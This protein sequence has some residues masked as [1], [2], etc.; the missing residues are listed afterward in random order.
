MSLKT[1]DLLSTRVAEPKPVVC[2]KV[3][4]AGRRR[5]ED[6]PATSLCTAI[7]RLGADYA[8]RP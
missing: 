1:T 2:C 3:V 5:M 7:K 6:R 8:S 4:D